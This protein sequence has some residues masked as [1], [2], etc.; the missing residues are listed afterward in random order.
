MDENNTKIIGLYKFIKE[1]NEIKRQTI[2]DINQHEWH[3]EIGKIPFGEN[4]VDIGYLD[5][6]EGKQ[7]GK[8]Y[9]LKVTKPEFT[10]CPEPDKSFQ[11]WLV[12][13]WDNYKEIPHVNNVIDENSEE[14]DFDEVE[15]FED[16][17]ERVLAYEAWLDERAQWVDEQEVIAQIRD[18]FIDLYKW[19]QNL[20]RDSETLEMM[21][22]CGFI[23]EKYNTALNHPVLVKRVR[24]ELDTKSNTM[25]VLD[26]DKDADLYTA[27]FQDMEDISQ[28]AINQTQTML[29][30]RG[31]HPLDR[32]DAPIFLK[33]FIYALSSKS[34]YVEE[35]EEFLETD[36]RFQMFC[37]PVL[38][39]RHRIDGTVKAIERIIE[40][41]QEF[42]YIPSLL[43]EI[44]NGGEI[45]LPE[46]E[47]EPTI[48]QQL[49]RVGGEDTDIFLSKEANREQ[50]EIAQRI[51]QY[52]AV[53]VQGPPG[54]GK[55]HTIANLL[56]HF[57]AQGKSVL[58]TSHT[59]KALSVLKEKVTLGLQDLC[60]SVIEESNADMERSIN[61]ISEKMAMYSSEVM[62][63]KVLQATEERKELINELGKVRKKLYAIKFSEQ[64]QIVF[65]GES[66]SPIDAAKLVFQHMNEIEYIPGEVKL[67]RALPISYEDLQF[68][69]NSNVEISTADEKEFE[70]DIPNPQE[71]MD[72]GL[73]EAKITRLKEIE[74]FREEYIRQYGIAVE[75]VEANCKE[76][77]LE[78]SKYRVE[79]FYEENVE[80]YEGIIDNVKDASD[81]MINI[82]SDA[83]LGNA[84]VSLWRLLIQTIEET[85]DLADSLVQEQ[86]GHKIEISDMNALNMLDVYQE[87][88]EVYE[89]KSKLNWFDN[90]LHKQYEQALSMV[91]VDGKRINNKQQCEMVLHQLQ[92]IQKRQ[93]CCNYWNE[94]FADTSMK[95]FEEL[96]TKNPENIAKHWIPKIQSMLS[97]FDKDWVLVKQTINKIGLPEEV[98]HCKDEAETDVKN[99]A[100]IFTR[101]SVMIP[102]IIQVFM[103][104]QEKER[105][106]AECEEMRQKLLNGNRVGSVICNDIEKALREE[107]VMAYEEALQRLLATF[108]KEEIK[109][110]RN[111]L[112]ILLK[113]VAPE[114][115]CNI[116]ERKEAYVGNQ[117]PS[118]I[119]EIWKW[120]QYA[121]ILADLTKEP[122]KELQEKS[123]RLSK[124]YR[125]I[126]AKVAEYKAWY[127]LLRTTESNLDLQ[128]ALQGWKQTV[129]KIGKGTGKTAPKLKA[130][131]R[132]LMAQC[133]K[134]V[135]C[136]IMPVSKALESLDP[137]TNRFDIVIVDEASQSSISAL[138]IL[139]FAKKAIIV[140]DDKQVS[141]M[142]IGEDVE[143]VEQMAEM[144]IKDNIPNWHLYTSD[145]S[146]YDVAA[147]TFKPLML[148]EH[149]RCYPDI[150]GFSNMLSYD[151]KINPL[152]DTSGSI[153]QPAVVNYRVADGRRADRR[154]INEKEAEAIVALIQ[155]C[156]NQPEYEGKTFGVISLLG[157][158][159][160]KLIQSKLFGAIDTAV[161]EERRILCGNSA[162]FQGDERD[163]IFL[164][165]VDSGRDG[166][167]LPMQGDGVK[168]ALKKR[169]NVAT[170]RARDQLW[171]VHSLDA[172]NDLKEGD[173]RKRLLDYAKNPKAFSQE[174]CRIENEADS[175]FEIEVGRALI[176]KGYHIVPQWQVGSYRIDMVAV[177]GNDK[178]AI[179]CDGEA[180][181]SGEAKIREDMERQTILER[182]GWRFI[183]IR[184][185]EYFRNP[186]ATME[187]VFGELE[188]YGIGYESCVAEA[189]EQSSEL[190]DRVKKGADIILNKENV[191]TI[192][193]IAT[194][195]YDI[196]NEVTMEAIE[197]DSEKSSIEAL[198]EEAPI[199]V[200]EERII[201]ASEE[202]L[203]Q[204]MTTVTNTI[205]KNQEPT[206][207]EVRE[208]VDELLMYIKESG[209][210]Y[211]DK[212]ANKGALWVVG[213]M[214]IREF[215]MECNKRGASFK[216]KAGGGNQ[217]K[218]K[219]AWWTK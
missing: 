112:L 122:Y 209:L 140:G 169:Y 127:Y 155:S 216:Y 111:K 15:H 205:E 33:Q 198:I 174:L 131:A 8:E 65:Q 29:Q 148:K 83:R 212:R 102:C 214:E 88:S 7:D 59:K 168:D 72:S 49:A 25:Y 172:A 115:A 56:G 44:V 66:V 61:G 116:S 189:E 186:E 136:W 110:R 91:L 104:I 28:N 63:K 159:Q 166:G 149:F 4:S 202:E 40:N 183:R 31:V 154:K 100:N 157:D 134:A 10:A 164:S 139:Y 60:V 78:G 184:G 54:T 201:R 27:L 160:V 194:M 18:L 96:D 210:A 99:V 67:Y 97:W 181:H 218:G 2:K 144:Y 165:M 64:D 141:P 90:L 77:I 12:A 76:I 103:W 101:I 6:V 71:L 26:T 55:T 105:I 175:P 130:Q 16:N 107:D 152:R 86:F 24:T 73:Y 41:I 135:P 20:D 196:K 192:H 173:I 70:S 87:L 156:I 147:T 62:N 145:T 92:L 46:I 121:G 123:L 177:C 74:E 158:E 95:K 150:I 120:K 58:V 34:K 213:G 199:V 142:A 5:R 79:E 23:Q 126:T 113:E 188:S 98:I 206:K 125:D 93:L 170:S 81:W 114:W 161:L 193:E 195:V 109:E 146:I 151:G 42:G 48:E 106:E 17:E 80:I 37:N 85:C 3:Q 137:K 129:K 30:E 43:N 36:V 217:T 185:S 1:L 163:V 13:G 182:L 176:A 162:N 11:E 207:V 211:Y 167:P 69:Y 21:I 119:E 94:L 191:T 45:E 9:L 35:Q 124:K 128:Q 215:I 108:R 132:Q 208:E 171:V 50:L 32:N 51:E 138:A 39:V 180:F 82:A 133:Q 68:L 143:K 187:R 53:L 57:L 178:V 197:A 203:G 200:E 204:G 52:N 118:D 117:V 38:F 75:K 47:D 14:V 179:E 219:D 19:H 22:G 89:K 153:L 190:L 84:K